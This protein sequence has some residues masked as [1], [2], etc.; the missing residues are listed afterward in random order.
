MTSSDLAGFGGSVEPMVVDVTD[1]L[2]VEAA[3]ARVL[4]AT[5]GTL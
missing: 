4:A 2:A 1:R 5:G 3:V